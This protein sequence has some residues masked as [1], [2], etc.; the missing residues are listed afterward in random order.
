MFVRK[1]VVE[2]A[3]KLMVDRLVKEYQPERV[4]LFGSYAYGQPREGSDL[5]LLIL[6]DTL[7]ESYLVE[8]RRVENII[9]DLG[10]SLPALDVKLMTPDELRERLELEDDFLL[11]ILQR[12]TILYESPAAQPLNPE[13]IIKGSK[14]MP[15][16]RQLIKAREWLPRAEEDVEMLRRALVYPEIVDMAAFHLQQA[17]EKYLKAYLLNKGWRL[18]RTHNLEALLREAIPFNSELEVFAEVCK[19]INPW[20]LAGRYPPFRRRAGQLAPP[21]TAEEVRQAMREVE[22]LIGKI[23][24]SIRP[25]TS[26][27]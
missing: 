9:G 25:T 12:G 24:Q 26:S 15:E 5:D 13:E 8:C 27:S 17:V 21:P 16:E 14:L 6:K 23:L 7:E 18:K 1:K 19:K 11:E 2:K 3:L 10:R 20:Y 4:V 22:P